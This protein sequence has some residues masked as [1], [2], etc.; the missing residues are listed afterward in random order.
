MDSNINSY[1]KSELC[2]CG[3]HISHKRL[4]LC[5]ICYL[6][7]RKRDKR[8][9]N[10]RI[11][12]DPARKENRRIK[13]KE[14]YYLKYRENRLAKNFCQCGS[15]SLKGSRYHFCASCSQNNRK[16]KKIQYQLKRKKEHLPTK[17]RE[18]IKSRLKKSFGSKSSSIVK[19]LG[20]SINDYRKYLE[21]KFQPG[22]TWENYGVNGWH[23]DHIVPLSTDFNDMSLYHYS[24]TQPLWEEEHF[25]KTAIENGLSMSQKT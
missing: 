2:S 7:K 20:C 23:I 17:I 15:V 4:K 13:S 8:A 18:N 12:S 14:R 6:L 24:N 16:E 9:C 21:S 1:I 10:A 11:A 25:A 22:M 3:S 5:D 19:F